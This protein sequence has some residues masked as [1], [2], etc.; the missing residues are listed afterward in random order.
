MSN[1]PPEIIALEAY[2]HA[3]YVRADLVDFIADGLTCEPG[4]DI[5]LH[6]VRAADIRDALR[7]P[8]NQPRTEPYPSP[9]PLKGGGVEAEKGYA[10]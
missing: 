7:A 8:E 9:P 5:A 10:K 6:M 2:G 4:T 3:Q 1:E